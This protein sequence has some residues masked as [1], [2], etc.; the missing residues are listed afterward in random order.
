[1]IE[2]YF[3]PPDYP[4]PPAP[5][6]RAV[7]MLEGLNRPR[8]VDFLVDTGADSTC[9]HPRDVLALGVDPG[10][11]DFKRVRGSQGIGGSLDYIPHNAVLIFGQSNSHTLWRCEI[12]I[13]DIWSDLENE[14]DDEDEY[15][16]GADW[17]PS[18][19]GRDFLNLCNIQMNASEEVFLLDPILQP[20]L[21][22][23]PPPHNVRLRR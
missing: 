13:C 15:E 9:L 21:M 23:W 4:G 8:P 7:I 5:Y 17:L 20:G 2:G 3:K 11:L 10:I 18:L 1:M 6:V 16:E 22:T 12:D 14:E 19:L